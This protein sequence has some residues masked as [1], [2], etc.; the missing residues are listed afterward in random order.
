MN[1]S[2][3]CRDSNVTLSTTVTAVEAASE[4]AAGASVGA[5]HVTMSACELEGFM[6]CKSNSSGQYL[7]GGSEHDVYHLKMFAIFA[8]LLSNLLS[9]SVVILVV[10]LSEPLHNKQGTLMVSYISVG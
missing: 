3:V 4:A 7:S 10:C 9:N 1:K 5:V 6:R 2:T 8:M